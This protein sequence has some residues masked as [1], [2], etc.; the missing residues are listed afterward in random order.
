MTLGNG[1]VESRGHDGRY[2]PEEIV[3]TGG[4]TVLDWAYTHDDVGN[5]TRIDDALDPTSPRVYGYQDLQYF[6]TQ[7]DGPWGTQS[8]TYDSIGNRLTEVRDGAAPDVYTYTANGI[9]G[10]TPLLASIDRT[11]VGVVTTFAYDAAGNQTEQQ[12]GSRAA[13]LR[14]RRRQPYVPYR[15]A[16]HRPAQRSALRRTQLPR[17]R[18][19][20]QHRDRLR[21]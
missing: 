19:A 8:W 18:R 13:H 6:L 2:F 7:G 21:R 11:A 5:V 3:V 17:P 15:A 10:N 20:R 16:G 12:G 14:I 4:S 1:L 9:A